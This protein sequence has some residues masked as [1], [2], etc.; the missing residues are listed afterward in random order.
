MLRVPAVLYSSSVKQAS[1]HIALD[2]TMETSYL[3]Q[4]VEHKDW[5]QFWYSRMTRQQ[6]Q[7]Q[8]Q[9]QQAKFTMI[10]PPP[11]VTG[12]LH[13]GHAL[14]L[15]IQ[16]ALSRWK[17]MNGINVLWVPGT[18]HAGIATQM[19]V[20]RRLKDEEG[21]DRHALGRD[22]FVERVWQWKKHYEDVI[23]QQMVH[24]TCIR[25]H[26]MHHTDGVNHYD[27]V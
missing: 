27:D 19:V 13:L 22:K 7:Q 4:S 26:S 20:E 14:T 18:D 2:S 24:H 12:S 10:F 23:V 17:R 11:N 16:D 6:Q 5:N 3:P 25:A 9:Q 1:F 15:S 8:Q 21:V